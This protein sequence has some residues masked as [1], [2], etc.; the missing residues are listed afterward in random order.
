[1]LWPAALQS[2]N[3][4]ALLRKAIDQI[5]GGQLLGDVDSSSFDTLADLLALSWLGR[6]IYENHEW[7][8]A[9]FEADAAMNADV[10]WRLVHSTQL[11]RWLEDGIVALKRAQQSK[12]IH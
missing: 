5:K 3:S 6:G 10:A 7:P 2:T 4:E 12:P 1:M 11:A 8:E 9:R